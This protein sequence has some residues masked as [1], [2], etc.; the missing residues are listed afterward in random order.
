MVL[1]SSKTITFEST[2]ICLYVA[3]CT[4]IFIAGAAVGVN[5]PISIIKL[6]QGDKHA[7]KTIVWL[8][9]SQHKDAKVD[10]NS[11]FH[12]TPCPKQRVAYVTYDGG[13]TVQC[14]RG[15]SLNSIPGK[16]GNTLVGVANMLFV[17]EHTVSKAFFPRYPNSLMVL[18]GKEVNDTVLLHDFGP[19]PEDDVCG[20]IFISDF[21]FWPSVFLGVNS[22]DITLKEKTRVLRSY[23]KPHIQITR[24]SVS[25]GTLVVHIRSGDVMR[26][27][28]GHSGY[29]QPPLAFYQSIILDNNFTSVVVVCE[30]HNN[31]TVDALAKWS[32]LVT[33]STG[34]LDEDVAI[35]LGASHLALS[36]GTFAWTIG[37]M[38]D[39]LQQLYVPCMPHCSLTDVCDEIPIA[40]ACYTF[41]NFTQNGEWHN[42]AAQR[43]LMLSYPVS[44]VVVEKNKIMNETN[45]VL[46][47]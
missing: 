8:E 39:S 7:V 36:Y 44:Y 47:S 25:P 32:D 38:A 13:N 33:F 23:L 2:N 31:P 41:P 15:F 42:T 40:A 9:E 43:E 45:D 6:Y 26:G 17:A 30:D 37:L 12:I 11:R 28:G 19:Q 22:S 3:I 5:R 35:I 34:Q 14:K 46:P 27:N 20:R 1:P 4:I 29:V 21:F 16:L 10:K 18:L 24:R